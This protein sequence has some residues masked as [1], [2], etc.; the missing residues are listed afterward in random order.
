[1][2]VV[3]W[4]VSL[5]II[6]LDKYY[7]YALSLGAFAGILGVTLIKWAVDKAVANGK[8][9]Y[10]FL[11]FCLRV[12]V[13]AGVIYVGAKLS[14]SGMVGACVGLLLPRVS[15]G[16]QQLIM[17]ALRKKT[18]GD[19]E[20]SYEPVAKERMLI[21]QPW[22]VMYRNGRKY[23]THKRFTRVAKVRVERT[24]RYQKRR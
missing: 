8:Q 14:T 4:V 16:V 19:D 18:G 17:P 24:P 22:H 21:K 13:Y 11:T 20:E 23:I 12:V 7:T 15:I 2:A 3:A 6:G 1:L 5:P 10:I 9:S